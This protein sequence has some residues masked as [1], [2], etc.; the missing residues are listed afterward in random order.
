M[1]H[2]A[3]TYYLP[4]LLIGVWR[5]Y[6]AVDGR[7]VHLAIIGHTVANLVS[8]VTAFGL[9]PLWRL[10]WL[11]LGLRFRVNSATAFLSRYVLPPLRISARAVDVIINLTSPRLTALSATIPLA[12]WACG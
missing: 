7:L 3:L 10:L 12:I 5:P 1:R 2:V 11:W 9:L 4:P 8:I 6:I